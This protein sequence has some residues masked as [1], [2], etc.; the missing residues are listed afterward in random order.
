MRDGNA[1]LDR[2]ELT[3]ADVEQVERFF[4]QA[5]R[6][7]GALLPWQEAEKEAPPEVLAL[8][9]DRL[10]ARAAKQWAESD[11]LRDAIAALGWVVED[12]PKG[13]RLKKI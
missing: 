9:Q 11:R 12:T 6:V 5:D 2:G 13:P 3:Q 7:V 4:A 1:A 10:A 8:V